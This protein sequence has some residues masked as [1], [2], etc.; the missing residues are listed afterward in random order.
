M[1]WWQSWSLESW[2]PR[3]STPF[4]KASFTLEPVFLLV[5]ITLN[6]AIV[7]LWRTLT[8]YS[9]H[10]LARL[11][12]KLILTSSWSLF[13]FCKKSH[14]ST[15]SKLVTTVFVIIYTVRFVWFG[16]WLC[17]WHCR[18]RRS[19]GNCAATK[20]LRRHDPHSH[21]CGGSFFFYFF[22]NGRQPSQKNMLCMF[23]DGPR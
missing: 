19:S 5:S 17:S 11:L 10:F 12:V 6:I 21:L 18:R 13:N 4:T 1:W 16:C 7:E 15:I 3:L 14:Q 8:K 22:F 20:A 23:R 2:M 9:V